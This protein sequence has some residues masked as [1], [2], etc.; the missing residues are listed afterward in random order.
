MTEE[1]VVFRADRDGVTAVLADWTCYAHVGQHS[2][3]SPGWYYTI[4]RPAKPHEYADLLVEIK[5]IYGDDIRVLRR[6]PRRN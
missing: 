1:W 2:S 6:K 4:T 5:Q 3:Y